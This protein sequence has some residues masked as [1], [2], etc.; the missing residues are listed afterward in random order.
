M[1]FH[2]SPYS[3]NQSYPPQE[4][5]QLANIFAR[6][7]VRSMTD[8]LA[9]AGSGFNSNIAAGVGVLANTY[10]TQG[11]L[12]VVRND[13][14]V[15]TLHTLPDATNPRIDQVYVKVYDSVDGGDASDSIPQALVLAGTPTGGATLANQNGMATFPFSGINN[16]MRVAKVLVPAGAASA[17]SFTYEDRRP[18][19]GGF[20]NI[21]ATESRTNTAYGVLTTP[22]QINEIV[23]PTNGIIEVLC[24]STWQ[25]S[26]AGAGRASLFL[27]A[28]QLQGVSPDGGGAGVQAALTNTAIANADRM[29]ISSPIGLISEAKN[30]ADPAAYT[31]DITTGQ[32]IGLAQGG[33]QAAAAWTT[34]LGTVVA[35]AAMGMGGP[36]HIFAAAGT[37]DISMQFKSSSGSVTAKNRKLWIRTRDA[38]NCMI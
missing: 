17:A 22:D 8:L 2:V 16:Y 38:S 10:Q 11:G 21:A 14:A 13:A 32:I 30:A 18:K 26:V 34:N 7:G 19:T 20:T 25:E 36:C 28:L 4:D 29:L 24:Q 5:R 12:Y 3:Q 33:T 1:A 6:P 31:G 37:Y 23:L 27:G 15:S 35:T 9:S